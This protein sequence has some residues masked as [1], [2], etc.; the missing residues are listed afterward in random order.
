MQKRQRPVWLQARRFLIQSK[1]LPYFK[2]L[3]KNEEKT[4]NYLWNK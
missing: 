4:A 1:R 3:L 2:Q